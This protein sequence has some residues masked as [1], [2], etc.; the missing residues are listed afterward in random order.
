MWNL[1]SLNIINV[2]LLIHLSY[3][4]YIFP[5]NTYIVL[6]GFD[7]F[8]FF[9]IREEWLLDYHQIRFKYTILHK[10]CSNINTFNVGC[11][12]MSLDSLITI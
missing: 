5:L 11:E 8:K 3:R 1:V 9:N 12:E 10:Y 6:A 4:K 7:F 2:F